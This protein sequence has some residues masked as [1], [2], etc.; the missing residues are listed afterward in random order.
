MPSP[1]K[2]PWLN[3]LASSCR[4][5]RLIHAV[6]AGRS[7][8][9]AAATTSSKPSCPREHSVSKFYRGRR[10]PSAPD[11]C[12]HRRPVCVSPRRPTEERHCGLCLTS[13][14]RTVLR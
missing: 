6:N 5:R 12:L 10:S 7:E 8:R 13:V 11:R 4:T 2:P 14:P 1:E 9:R 3:G